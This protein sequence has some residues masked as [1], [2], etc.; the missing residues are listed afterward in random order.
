MRGAQVLIGVEI[1][2]VNGLT[3]KLFDRA[4]KKLPET[5]RPTLLPQHS[6]IEDARLAAMKQYETFW[7]NRGRIYNMQLA[8]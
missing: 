4:H 8:I 7:L 6:T 5:F 3:F 1:G 2:E